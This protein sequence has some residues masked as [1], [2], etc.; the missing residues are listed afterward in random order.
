MKK[1]LLLLVFGAGLARAAPGST[2]VGSK[3]DFS[4]TGPAQNRVDGARSPCAFCHAS[5]GGAAGLSNRPD[6]RAAYRTRSPGQLASGPR[7]PGGS[8]RVCL[9]CHDGTVAVG[10]T[11]VSS[12]SRPDAQRLA[13]GTRSNLGTDL[14][15]SHPISMRSAP[16]HGTHDPVGGG[17]VSLD[18]GGEVQCT[19]CHDP[20]RQNGDPLLGEFLVAPT[21][22]STLCL[23]CHDGAAVQGAN[24]A[25]AASAVLLPA[26]VEP[27]ALQTVGGAG[28]LACHAAHGARPDTHLVVRGPAGDDDS[29][30]L[31]CHAGGATAGP[32]VG[33]DAAKPWS[34]AVRGPH[35]AA[36]GPNSASA[37]LPE[38]SPGARRHAA[39]VDCHDPH[40]AGS[41]PAPRPFAGGPLA[42]VW[43][44]DLSGVRVETV[45]FEYEVCFKCHADSANQPQARGPTPPDTVRRAVTEVNLRRV[46]AVAAP[47]AH[48]V[49]SP[50]R[51]SD[52]P[53]LVEPWASYPSIACSDCHASSGSSVKGPHG[54]VYPHLLE[55]QYL[56]ADRTPESPQAYALCYKCHD[57]DRLLAE[58]GT[59]FPFHNRH[60]VQKGTACATCHNAHGI[61]DI[62]GTPTANAHLI[63]FDL[64]VVGRSAT[65]ERAY[66][67]LG[68]RTGSCNLNC[69]GHEH[70]GLTTGK[71]HP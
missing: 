62:A 21:Q 7:L 2:I 13:P 42:G 70:D 20:H 1:A 26:G 25:H 57:R 47:S 31:R 55:R 18:P 29:A 44:I 16:G 48:D 46:F 41:A 63:D 17:A 56:S 45:R 8:S 53:S 36:E 50:R 32:N 12:D 6:S 51:A 37:R 35:D 15:T 34:H 54:S 5:H 40:A 23:S 59:P 30:C 43:G 3:H 19:S 24:S 66:T 27:A 10:S 22:R 49:A 60:V 67:R 61:S 65:G 68:A 11:R 14:R 4:A 38:D 33:L 9:S 71:Y 64:S 69:H 58:T 52:V 39:C 28:C